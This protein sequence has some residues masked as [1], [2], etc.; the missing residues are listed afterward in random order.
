MITK[1]QQM[2]IWNTKTLSAFNNLNFDMMLFESDII[3]TET[4]ITPGKDYPHYEG[5]E[6]HK[7]HKGDK[8]HTVYFVRTED[9]KNMPLLIKPE[10]WRKVHY[11]KKVWKMITGATPM[12]I[13]P[14]KKLS[15]RQLVDKSGIP[16][17]S[18]YDLHYTLY[19]IKVLY[20]LT[21]GSFYYR[22]ITKSRFGK[23]KYKEACNILLNTG[24]ILSDPTVANLF[25]RACHCDDI[26]INELP[27]V[28]G[29]EFN[30]LC[31]NF[32]RIGDGSTRIDNRARST[33]GTSDVANTE[34][35][36][37]SFTHNIP[38]Y[39]HDKGRKSFDDLFPYNV[40]SRYFYTL[41]E[42]HLKASFPHDMNYDEL[43]V[44][45]EQIIRDWIKSMLWYKNNWNT[46]TNNYPETLI[47][48][49]FEFADDSRFR[50]Y[51]IDF[52][53]AVAEY[54]E[55][56]I[57]IYLKLLNSEYKAHKDY[58][59]LLKKEEEDIDVWD[60]KKSKV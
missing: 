60:W 31:N 21:K 18:N 13:I 12:R 52:S 33:T 7:K 35:L 48:A 27:T 55:G 14:E 15:F 38:K 9:M 8:T 47:D 30:K 1:E 37:V 28:T 23:D 51:F 54:S 42:G 39:Y 4:Y 36:T 25:Y 26:T 20:G 32:M 3:G 19:K 17:H 59:A 6:V 58:E 11:N 57:K 24:C 5:Y 53:R 2:L 10:G 16:N 40:T 34:R 44:E 29:D 41:Y 45:H 50:D 49:E 43:A 46:V 22:V 56:D